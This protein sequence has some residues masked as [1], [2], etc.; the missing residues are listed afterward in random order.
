M[1]NTLDTLPS[2]I[3][4]GLCI[5]TA[6]DRKGIRRFYCDNRVYDHASS[7]LCEVC[8]ENEAEHAECQGHPPGSF[9]PMGETVYCNGSC[10]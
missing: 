1:T 4:Q 6:L 5:S 8:E 9:E 7:G 2:R 3:S 10:R